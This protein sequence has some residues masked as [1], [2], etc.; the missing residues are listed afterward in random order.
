MA[1]AMTANET[2]IN[3]YVQDI[4]D[5][6]N[7]WT[8]FTTVD[9]MRTDREKLQPLKDQINKLLTGSKQ[10]YAIATIDALWGAWSSWKDRG[11]TV[12]RDKM[13]DGLK[14]IQAV[15]S[16]APDVVTN[17]VTKIV[18]EYVATPATPAAVVTPVKGIPIWVWIGIPVVLIGVFAVPKLI[19]GKR[20]R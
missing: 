15:L 19:G 14:K 2:L 4:I 18:T 12:C 8:I 5:A 11:W 10:D 13:I 20:R 9:T 7:K 16:S 3:R 1:Y 6:H 17:E